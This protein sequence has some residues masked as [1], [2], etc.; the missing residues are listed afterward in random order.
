M[1]SRLRSFTRIPFT[2]RAFSSSS[3]VSSLNPDHSIQAGQPPYDPNS[4]GI[5]LFYF[6]L[7]GRAEQARLL[8][9]DAGIPYTDRLLTQ[10]SLRALKAAGS[11]ISNP[12]FLKSQIS[13]PLPFGSLPL[14]KDGDFHL[15]QT[16]A[17]L[18]YLAMKGDL[19]YEGN[20]LWPSNF[21]DQAKVQQCIAGCED[22]FQLYWPI[23]LDQ[24]RYVYHSGSFPLTPGVSQDF[25]KF[26]STYLPAPFSHYSVP[27]AFRREG[28]PRWLTYFEALIR[29]N[30]SQNPNSPYL[31]GSSRTYADI[32]LFNALDAVQSI[33]SECLTPFAALAKLYETI[34]NRPNI[35]KYLKNRPVSGL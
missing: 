35:A 7:Y 21:V 26:P 8:M 18:Q 19:Q 27:R 31:V 24:N 9:Q 16:S 29:R 2:C 11:P 4:T 20:G 1:L 25:V 32:S 12:D 14:L 22:L 17:I 23:K 15:S 33:D 3:S 30:Q 34:K 13:S 5:S 28:L 6:A 10:W